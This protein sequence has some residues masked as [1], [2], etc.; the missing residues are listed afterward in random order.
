L[1][2]PDPSHHYH[3]I[4]GRLAEAALREIVAQLQTQY[5]FEYSIGVMPITV[6][7]LMT[8]RWLRRHLNVPAQATHLIVPGYCQ[9]DDD[10]LDR[11]FRIPVI[12]GPRD[13]RFLPELFGKTVS[14]PDL[15][16]YS[17]EIIAEINH[18]PRMS[19][20]ECVELA[21]QM[22]R[23]GADRIDIGCD[24]VAACTRIGDHV[25][26]V[27]D[28]GV[29]VSIDTFDP[30]EA[31]SAIKCGADL[32]LSVNG[33][34]LSQAI[35]YGCEV[36]VVPDSPRDEKSLEKNIEFLLSHS[37]PMR[38]DP[39]LEPIGSGFAASLVRYASVRLR[40]P[41]VP[42]MMGIGNLT[43]LT[44]VDSAG[45]NLILLA[46]CQ[47]LGVES[48]LT[49]QVI[50]WARTSVRECDFAR[51]LV[52]Y[53][54]AHGVPPK[55]LSEELVIL[56]DAKLRPFPPAAIDS[57]ASEIKDNNYRL[58]AQDGVLHLV[59]AGLHLTGQD[60]FELFE[61]LMQQPQSDNVDPGHAFYLGYEM[62]KAVTALQL[63]KQYEQDRALN[64]GHLTVPED[65]HRIQRTSRHRKNKEP[66]ERGEN[67]LE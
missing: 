50:N 46:V 60:P 56:R 55:R 25:S 13:C 23:D 58:F 53:C 8:P 61:Q 2:R 38:V 30:D 62:A 18:A 47:E 49:T 9:S 41:D 32:V 65:L 48:V 21:R 37:I 1:L 10:P 20:K 28:L 27:V 19:V 36:V 14:P 16:R 4:T 45:V 5:K 51:K 29:R 15:S 43:E 31:L 22:I 66:I 7:A 6:A 17:I 57:L 26:A 33:S 44:D 64:W 24:P 35:Q 59:S 3:F 54:V 67:Q 12:Y 39:I 11:G 52:H 34:N 40:Y 42:M 63:G